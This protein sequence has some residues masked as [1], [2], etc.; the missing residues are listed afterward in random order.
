M[1]GDLLG[2]D[3]AIFDIDLVSDQTD[4]DDIADSGQIL[5]PFRHVLIGDSRGDIKHDDS[6]LT[7]N[8]VAITKA[9]ELLLTGGIPDVELDKALI[10]MER[11]RAYLNTDGG[12]VLFL[13]LTSG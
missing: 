4:R 11:H 1:E 7:A 5:V 3:F 8:V 12:I 2:L 6:A 13:E 9:T 10:S